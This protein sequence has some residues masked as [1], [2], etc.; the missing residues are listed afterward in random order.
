MYGSFYY[1][2]LTGVP[3][4]VTTF[5]GDNNMNYNKER[6]NEASL[7]LKSF[8]GSPSL[9]ACHQDET[10]IHYGLKRI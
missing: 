2:Q 5:R 7:S 10:E 6:Q 8:K 3:G 1:T 9:H 4:M